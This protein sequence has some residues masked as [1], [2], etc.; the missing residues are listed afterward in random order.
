MIPLVNLE[1]QFENI[2]SEVFAKIE[3]VCLS[4][5]FIDGKYLA[6][7]EREFKEIHGHD[8]YGCGASSGTTALFLALKALNVGPGDEV[9]TTPHTFIATAE[10]ICHV[11]AKPVFVDI[12]PDTYT[13]DE[14]KIEAAITRRTKA[15]IP[16]HIY[17]NVCNMK[18]IM[19][20]AERRGLYVIEDCAQ[21]HL[22]TFD[23]QL[24]GT[25]GDAA[26]FSFFPGKNLGA[27]GDAGFVLT[28]HKHL[29]AIMRKLSNHGRTEKYKHDIIGYN[30]R[31]D[32]IQAAI[33]SI[34]LNYLQEWT[35]KRQ[36]KTAIYNHAFAKEGFQIMKVPEEVVPVYHL[37]VVQVSNRNGTLDHLRSKGI[38]ASIH[39]PI[40]LHLQPAFQDLGYQQGD[41]PVVERI[42]ERVLSLPLCSE[43]TQEQLE[44]VRDE[45]LKVAKI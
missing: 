30:F 20:I 24:V 42:A 7:F 32:D 41:L 27:F 22:A 3:E 34:K 36:E 19:D 13:I 1:K 31:M 11:G 33:L 21:S 35:N 6:K 2:K 18:A 29:E 38:L 23:G 16:V 45:F 15:I 17:G 5:H 8:I 44:Y 4:R 28:R 26:A 40:P 9:I 14:T 25:F 12:H 10:A 39:Y 37:Y 43:I